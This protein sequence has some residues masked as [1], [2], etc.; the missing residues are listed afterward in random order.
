[1]IQHSEVVKGMGL[2]KLIGGRIIK[3]SPHKV[4]R[5]I[6]KQGSMISLLKERTGCKIIVGQNGKVW[7]KGEN[8]ENEMKAVDAIKMIN[9]LAHTA[10]LTDKISEFLGGSANVQKEE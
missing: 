8:F 9:D 5:I 7:I 4:P 6:G 2:R 3:V 10:G 1:M